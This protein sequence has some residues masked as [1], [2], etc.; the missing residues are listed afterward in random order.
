MG[1]P[2]VNRGVLH[3]LAQK[4]QESTAQILAACEYFSAHGINGTQGG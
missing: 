4:K 2:R 1:G 3:P